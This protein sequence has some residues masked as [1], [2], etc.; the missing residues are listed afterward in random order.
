MTKRQ[1]LK[2]LFSLGP[3]RKRKTVDRAWGHRLAS[4]K[5]SAGF[6]K[7]LEGGVYGRMRNVPRLAQAK[8]AVA[9]QA[10]SSLLDEARSWTDADENYG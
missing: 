10:V 2:V 5:Y 7:V 1:A 6:D 9:C 8:R 4:Y 3:K